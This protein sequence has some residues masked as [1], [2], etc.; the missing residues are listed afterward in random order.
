ME[1]RIDK[2]DLM[3]R[4]AGW[5]GFLKRSVHLITCG[6]TALTLLGIKTSTKDIDLIVPNLNEYEY[7]IATL[8][9]L[10]LMFQKVKLI[11]I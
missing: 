7:L 5:D 1:Y 9:Q 10:L 3:D 4:I 6:G 8:K 11:K 2:Q